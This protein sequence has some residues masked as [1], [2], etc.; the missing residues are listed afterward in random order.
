MESWSGTSI[1]L[2]NNENS[3]ASY[4]SR[5]VWEYEKPIM[6]DDDRARFNDVRVGVLWL[7]LLTLVTNVLLAL[8]L[9]RVW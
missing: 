1:S 8:V 7:V 3:V 2:E 5:V 6:S 9:W 4:I